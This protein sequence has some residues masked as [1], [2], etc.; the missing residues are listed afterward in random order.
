GPHQPLIEQPFRADDTAGFLVVSEVKFERSTEL[1]APCGR[2]F[3]REQRPG[4]AGKIRFRH[5]HAAS[6][7]DRTMRALLDDRPV[8]I[9]APSGAGG[10]YVPMGIERDAGP[11]AETMA[12]NQMVTLFMP[13]A[14]PA[15]RGTS[16]VSTARPSR[17][18]SCRAR[19]AC[20]AQSPGGLSLGTFTNSAR[21]SVSRKK[22]R[23]TNAAMTSACIM[24]FQP[25][26][27]RH[28]A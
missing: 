20:A 25:A 23:S 11:I 8:R 9:E 10:H 24:T 14:S 12:D 21:N 18:S 15:A 22:S 28:R 26:E 13:A 27:P 1:A 2:R 19:F 3:Q 17:S 16:C 7:H 5:R 6:I 4:V